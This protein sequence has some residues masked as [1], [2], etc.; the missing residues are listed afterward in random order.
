MEPYLDGNVR[1]P[2]HP[3]GVNDGNFTEEAAK[4]N[5]LP[6]LPLD[7]RKTTTL[8]RHYY[9]EGGWGWVVVVCAVLVHVLN[10]GVQ[11]SCSQLVFPGAEKFKVETVHFADV[12]QSGQLPNVLPKAFSKVLTSIKEDSLKHD[13]FKDNPK[14]QR[15]APAAIPANDFDARSGHTFPN[16][17]DKISA[18]CVLFE[19]GLVLMPRS[20]YAVTEKVRHLHPKTNPKCQNM[21]SQDFDSPYGMD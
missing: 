4:E 16:S 19:L 18:I 11:L 15:D 5:L 1:C 2:I 3:C 20:C 17:D 7:A 6:D 10:H 13:R 14:E 12:R 9:P 8:R 21:N